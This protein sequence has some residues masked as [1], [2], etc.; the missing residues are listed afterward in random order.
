MAKREV[1][2]TAVK[3][4]LAQRNAQLEALEGENGK[5][6]D[7]KQVDAWKAGT[8]AVAEKLTEL[9]GLDQKWY[10][11]RSEMEK[12]LRAIEAGLGHT[13]PVTTIENATPVKPR[14]TA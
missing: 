4:R 11:I 10:V 12:E 13:A 14:Q 2:F 3:A 5:G 6:S 9:Q 8:K 7:H 1:Y